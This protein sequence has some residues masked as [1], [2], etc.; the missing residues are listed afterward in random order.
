MAFY[1]IRIHERD[2]ITRALVSNHF[3]TLYHG[4]VF[5]VYETDAGRPH[6]QGFIWA[7][8]STETIR[9]RLRKA[10]NVKGN[11][12]YH[13]G[14]L[15]DY[16]KTVRYFCKGTKSEL[17]D[18]VYRSAIDID[19]VDQH[20]KYWEENTAL[21]AKVKKEPGAKS[22]IETV[23]DE[24]KNVKFEDQGYAKRRIVVDAIMRHMVSRNSGISL[25]YVRSIFNAVMCRIDGEYLESF[26]HE[27]ISK[28]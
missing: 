7:D 22:L 26:S 28:F 13:V 24:M 8:V 19:V 10:F 25:F 12:E 1:D 5:I 16:E 2:D 18:V 6:Y 15:R 4:A 17:P 23:V 21:K 11:K 27:V 20:R 14:V 3:A 9:D